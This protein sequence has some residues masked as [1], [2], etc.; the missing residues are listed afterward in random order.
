MRFVVT[1]YEKQVKAGR[2]FVHENPARAKSWALPEIRKM[3][4]KA[5]VDV[6]EVDQCMY[7]LKTWGKC[8]S[9]L[10]LANKPTKFMTNSRTIGR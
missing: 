3:M 10:V 4:R 7:G 9:Q 8:R 5:G 6:Y 1:L 2:V